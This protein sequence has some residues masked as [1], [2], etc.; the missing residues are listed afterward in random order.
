M[1]EEMPMLLFDSDM[2]DEGRILI[3]KTTD[4]GWDTCKTS[5]FFVLKVKLNPTFR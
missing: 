3:L 2:E 5:H 1:N 4:I